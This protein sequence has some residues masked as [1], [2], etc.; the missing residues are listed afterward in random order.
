M[1]AETRGQ[2]PS[3]LNTNTLGVIHH[4]KH[5]IDKMPIRPGNLYQCLL[6]YR[7]CRERLEISRHWR[8]TSDML[9]PHA[10]RGDLGFGT[11]DYAAKQHC[12]T[13]FLRRTLA[14]HL[15]LVSW[16]LPTPLADLVSSDTRPTFLGR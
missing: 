15:D 16:V 2:T 13:S 14:L 9:E 10:A 11:I 4:V 5:H 1:S 8:T 7:P 3:W 6:P 12:P